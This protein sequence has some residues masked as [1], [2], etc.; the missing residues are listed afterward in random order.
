MTAT[1]LFLSAFY[2][3]ALMNCLV[4]IV[5]SSICYVMSKIL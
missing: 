5:G 2:A 1:K 3:G 4:E